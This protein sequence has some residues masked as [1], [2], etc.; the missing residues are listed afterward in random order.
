MRSLDPTYLTIGL[1]STY[2]FKSSSIFPSPINLDKFKHKK[3]MKAQIS[4]Q[5]RFHVAFFTK[6]KQNVYRRLL[7]LDINLYGHVQ[8]CEVTIVTTPK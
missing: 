5:E 3:K 7:V 6:I 4:E 8:L 2:T 1:S